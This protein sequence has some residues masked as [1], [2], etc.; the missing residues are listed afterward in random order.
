MV[1]EGNNMTRVILLATVAVL[2]AAC[3]ASTALVDA[4]PAQIPR[5]DSNVTP[6]TAYR[7]FDF[8]S[9]TVDVSIADTP[10]LRE[11][12][13]YLESNPSLDIGID[14]TLSAEGTSL[15]DRNLSERRAASVRRALMDTGA[16][17]ASYKIMMGPFARS[18]RG[19][20]G[21]IQVLVGPRTGSLKVTFASR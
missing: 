14:G 12:V 8:E 3:G 15:A 17:V 10:K 7:E 6:W 16:G 20:A 9:A 4:I 1:N 19:R 21:Q 13:A 5:A 18:N 2:V 11:I